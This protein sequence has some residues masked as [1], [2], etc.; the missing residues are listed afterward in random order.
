MTVYT[1]TLTS[2]SITIN[3]ED[4]ISQVSVQADSTSGTF[5]VIGTGTFQGNDS[6]EVTITAGQG[7]EAQAS[8]PQ[9]PI[10]GVTI[11]CL[12]GSIKISMAGG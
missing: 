5:S 3:A 2:G 6:D 4:G 12:A 10:Q 1:T 9:S 11:T 7:W 8:S